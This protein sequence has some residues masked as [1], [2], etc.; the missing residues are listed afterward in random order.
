MVKYT[1]AFFSPRASIVGTVQSG[2]IA[3]EEYKLMDEIIDQN[4][5]TVE[6]EGNKV[7]GADEWSAW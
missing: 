4:S 6:S 7:G 1:E 2:P 5:K 3:S